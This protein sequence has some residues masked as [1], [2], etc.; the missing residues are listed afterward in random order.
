MTLFLLDLPRREISLPC[1]RFLQTS[2]KSTLSETILARYPGEIE[3]HQT[4]YRRNAIPQFDPDHN[5]I[6]TLQALNKENGFRTFTLGSVEFKDYHAL[7]KLRYQHNSDKDLFRQFVP[8]SMIV[9]LLTSDNHLVLGHRG[10]EHLPN[11][12]LSPAGF[13]E[14]VQDVTPSYFQEK[15]SEELR[16]EVGISLE[17]DVSYIG[18]TGD[19]RDSFLTVTIFLARTQKTIAEVEKAWDS[20]GNKEEHSH[21]IYLPATPQDICNFL[22]GTYSGIVNPFRD[23]VFDKGICQSGPKEILHRQYQQIENGIGSYL[24]Y[25]SLSL[26]PERIAQEAKTLLAS[27]TLEALVS[28]TLSADD[29]FLTIS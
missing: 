2:E 17:Q 21:L 28:K 9:H 27:G 14:C 29:R 5:P 25:L 7:K 15:C 16:E 22:Q 11:R 10:G 4:E 23:I 3:Q 13:Q 20:S 18:L 26:S 12:Y 1:M 19:T 8:L 24:A 6:F